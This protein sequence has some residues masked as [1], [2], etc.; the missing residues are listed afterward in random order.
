M[1]LSCE[2]L[3]CLEDGLPDIAKWCPE[4]LVPFKVRRLRSAKVLWINS[5]WFFG[6]GLDLA[7]SRVV[8]RLKNWLVSTFGYAVPNSDDDF[9]AY[10]DETTEFLADRYGSSSGTSKHGGSGRAGIVGRFQAKGVGVTPL[11]GIG[12]DW[13]HSNGCAS[14]EEAVREAIYSEVFLEEFPHGGAPVIAILDV[15]IDYKYF[16]PGTGEEIVQRRAI[17]IRPSVLRPAHAERAPMFRQSIAYG[18]SE[19]VDDV[20]RCRSFMA[21]WEKASNQ[22]EVPCSLEVLIERLA[23]QVA[24][25]EIHRLFSGGYFS[26]NVMLDGGLVD[27]GGA[28][29]LPNWSYAIT[30]HQAPGSGGGMSYIRGIIESLAFHSN[31]YGCGASQEFTIA[32]LNE[33]ARVSHERAIAREI[34]RIWGLIDIGAES[35][36]AA[37]QACTLKYYRWQQRRKVDYAEE[38]VKADWIYDLFA[39]RRVT[40]SDSKIHEQVLLDTIES[41]LRA[42]FRKEDEYRRR[43]RHLQMSAARYFRP[44]VDLERERLQGRLFKLLNRMGRA[45]GGASLPKI[46]SLI[47]S[48]V[49]RS[50]RHWP[51]LPD[52]FGVLSHVTAGGCSALVC[53]DV[54]TSETWIWLEGVLCSG[55]QRLFGSWLQ[56]A[57]LGGHHAFIHG[58]RWCAALPIE[59]VSFEDGRIRLN[60]DPTI[61][62]PRMQV[63]YFR[64][65]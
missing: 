43:R 37:I 7:D 32:R 9:T 30:S 49:G 8:S 17:I 55:R 28:R 16:K 34:L 12:C 35:V 22:N 20:R 51:Q 6:R 5:R 42:I 57:A 62:I 27:F 11:A 50:R 53:I 25:G 46:T 61:L 21:S 14:L 29:A 65:D 31:K 45:P 2:E 54:D 26:S 13:I 10:S 56:E 4:A 63:E 47:D 24:F 36:C 59:N 44:R 15:G 48:L 64:C 19:Q 58:N 52:R 3:A 40:D 39:L 60:S 23:S 1:T 18:R 33:I 41:E 38:T